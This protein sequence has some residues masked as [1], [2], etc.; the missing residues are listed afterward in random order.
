VPEFDAY[1]CNIN[2]KI[3]RKDHQEHRVEMVKHF[4]EEV[5]PDTDVRC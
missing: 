1:R 3:R 2:E 4:C 5:P